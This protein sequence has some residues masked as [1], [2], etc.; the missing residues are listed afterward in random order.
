[1]KRLFLLVF[2]VLLLPSISYAKDTIITGNG[3]N[4]PYNCGCNDQTPLPDPGTSN[5]I[6]NFVDGL[7]PW[8][9]SPHP[10]SVGDQITV[11]NSGGCATYT[12]TS[13]GIWG[14]GSYSK[15]TNNGGGKCQVPMSVI[16]R[17]ASKIGK[18]GDGLGVEGGSAGPPNKESSTR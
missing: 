17:M 5:T 11:C 4:D 9:G 15:N 12:L 8:T 18:T 3:T 2:M 16:Q 6:N 10:E 1:M 14:Q 7:G 13:S